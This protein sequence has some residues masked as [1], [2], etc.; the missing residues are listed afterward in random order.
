MAW[1]KLKYHNNGLTWRKTQG[2]KEKPKK[3]SAWRK[4]EKIK[5]FKQTWITVGPTWFKLT[6]VCPPKV[7]C[8]HN[9]QTPS[10]LVLWPLFYLNTCMTV[11]TVA[12]PI[13]SLELTAYEDKQL[14]TRDRAPL[15]FVSKCNKNCVSAVFKVLRVIGK[16]VRGKSPYEPSGPS[17]RCLFRFL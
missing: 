7:P 5:I 12:L 17:G 6:S 15:L 3:G 9:A 1:Y 4:L 10:L 11:K 16:G 2:N 13:W 8:R 14:K